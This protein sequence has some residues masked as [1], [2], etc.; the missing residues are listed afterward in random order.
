M[1]HRIRLSFDEQPTDLSGTVQADETYIGGLEKNRHASA[2][3]NVGRGGAGKAVVMG[4]MERGGK[5]RTRKITDTT[6]GTLQGEIVKHVQAGSTLHTDALPSYKNLP[7]EYV[8]EFVDHAIEYVRDGVHT[9]G[10]ENFFSLLK[11]MIKGTYV[12]VDPVHLKAYL[13]E[14][15]FRYNERKCNDAQRFDR[16]LRGVCGKRLTYKQLTALTWF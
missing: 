15:T 16:A 6:K 11:R 12:S 2:K 1:L 7:A 9:S 5:A 10:L 3:K 13:D 14:Q 8:H 4:I